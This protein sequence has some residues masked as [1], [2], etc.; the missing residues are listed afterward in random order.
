MTGGVSILLL[1]AGGSTR[2]RGD[3]KLTRMLDGEPLLRRSARIALASTAME[4]VV[5]LGANRAARER[6]LDGLPVRIAANRDWQAGMG[7]SISAGMGAIHA[8]ARAVVVMLADMPAITAPL[9]DRLIAAHDSVNT[10]GIVRPCTAR[11]VMGHPV[12][13]G[14]AHFRALA[15]LS[16]DEGARAILAAHSDAMRSVAF[17][18]DAALVDLDT[19]E[20]WSKWVNGQVS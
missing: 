18:E 14:A 2:M 13:F 3:D 6:C 5:V 12:L 1:A 20:A 11:G 16:G 10:G 9:L 19:P 15:S 4:T 17:P 8:R 7:A